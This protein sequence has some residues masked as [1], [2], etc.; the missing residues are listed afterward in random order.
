MSTTRSVFTIQR[1]FFLISLLIQSSLIFGQELVS[2][3]TDR[4]VYIAGEPVWINVKCVKAGTSTA[5]DLSKVAYIELINAANVPV[6]Q[7]KLHLN[8]NG[9]ASTRFVLPDTL[10]TD[11]YRLRGYTKWMRNYNADLY[12]SR[13]ISVVNPFVNKTFPKGDK[14]FSSDTVIFYPEG[15]RIIS[16]EENRLIFQSLDIFAQGISVDGF[17]VSGSG[18][19]VATVTSNAMGIGKFSLTPE[20][21]SSYS[22]LLNTTGKTVPLSLP[23]IEDSGYGIHLEN[24]TSSKTV[25]KITASNKAIDEQE[26][27][28]LH[29]VSAGGKFLKSYPVTVKSGVQIVVEK[30][31]LPNTLLFASLINDKGEVLSSRY[32]KFSAPKPLSSI[33]VKMDK[34]TYKTRSKV[35]FDIVN[36]HKL[37]DISVSVVKSCLLNDAPGVIGNSGIPE[38]NL[39]RWQT[40]EI[41]ENDLLICYKPVTDILTNS[42][43]IQFLPEMEGEIIS[44][45]ILNKDSNE[46][47]VNKSYI[48]SFVGKVPVISITE[49]DSSGRFNYISNRYGEREIVIQPM[50]KDTTDLNYRI[51]LDIPF[52]N[53]YSTVPVKPLYMDSARVAGINRA[54]I[55]MQLNMVYKPY[56]SYPIKPVEPVVPF[57]FYG[58]PESTV[59]L[60]HF[61]ELPTME[62]VIREIVPQVYLRR[63]KGKYYFYIYDASLKKQNNDIVFSLVDG[64]P[65]WDADRILMINPEEMDRIE[66]IRHNYYLHR[67]NLGAILNLF[68]TKG[69]LSAMDFDK[70]IFRQS[71]QCYSYSYN[72]NSPDY[73]IDSVKTSRIPDFRNLLYWNPEISFDNDN[74]ASV[75]FYTSD[76][77]SEYTIIVE[78]L[79]AEGIFER[80][81][82]P[83]KVT[84]K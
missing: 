61:I 33:D 44:G 10:S 70:R 30:G 26:S 15:G 14:V 77:A 46:P 71:Q 52:S 19:T 63:D 58:K 59:A 60:G 35:S 31:S 2:F 18:D 54:I 3:R 11:N 69:D 43:Q 24:S 50:S 72:F 23:R 13:I 9:V 65:V 57:P 45:V 16:G 40:D 53:S 68:T 48:L 82:Y 74:K 78:G 27:G 29:I 47:I 32:F 8:R 36:S 80:T 6:T 5:S 73:S 1:L 37:S 75:V 39:S 64:V 34:A 22:F 12:F 79:N 55:N 25:F 81:Q 56:N 62:D 41:S 4:D 76:E 66:V 51:N 84:G 42:Q 7:I 49:T 83:F 38:K 17:I 67:Y 20:K 28:F 21:N